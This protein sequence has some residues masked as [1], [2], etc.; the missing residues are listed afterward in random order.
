M[1]AFVKCVEVESE[2]CCACAASSDGWWVSVV[3][4]I[5]C[6]SFSSIILISLIWFCDDDNKKIAK[7][8]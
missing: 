5:A 3:K 4:G 6:I 1:F 8:T 2:D 7:P